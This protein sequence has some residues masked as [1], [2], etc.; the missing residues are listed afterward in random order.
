MARRG[1][2]WRSVETFANSSSAVVKMHRG[3]FAE[4]ADHV[5]AAVGSADRIGARFYVH[6]N[7][8]TLGISAG[9][10][11]TL[12]P[13][14]V[15]L[16]GDSLREQREVGH[17]RGQWDVLVGTLSALENH[18]RADLAGDIL[19]TIRDTPLATRYVTRVAIGMLPEVAK[20]ADRGDAPDL[21]VL[22]GQVLDALDEIVDASRDFGTSTVRIVT[23]GRF[24]LELDGKEVPSSVWGSKRARQLCKQLVAVR[25][26]PITR[27]QLID[28]LWPD[29]PAI[30][31]LGA[32]LSV[33]LSTVRRAL[34]G[35]ID[36][37]RQTVRLDL[38]EVSTDLEELYAANDDDAVVA[39][40]TGEFL[41]EDRYDDWTNGTS[42]PLTV[43]WTPPPP[44]PPTTAP[45]PIPSV[46]ELNAWLITSVG[47]ILVVGDAPD[48]PLGA[49]ATS[50][51]GAPM[52]GSA[53]TPSGGVWLAYSDGSVSAHGVEWHGDMAGVTLTEPIT[54]IAP[55]P[56][57]TGYWLLGTDGGVF[58]FGDAPFE[59]SPAGEGLVH[60]AVDL[61]ITSSGAGY[62]V[63]AS[64]GEVYAYGD[65]PYL[66]GPNTI[67]GGLHAPATSIT[68]GE[69]GYWVI[70][71]DG[72]V[73]AYDE[74]F[75]GSLPSV[76]P[77]VSLPDATRIRVAT[78]GSGYYITTHDGIVYEFGTVDEAPRRSRRAR[79]R[80]GRRR[81]DRL[82]L[83]A[84]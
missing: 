62:W 83:E 28:H 4:A 74:A 58:A 55:A 17:V 65:A 57:G 37:D 82:R 14:D 9:A 42:A 46:G 54:G 64:N 6:Y 30:D 41:P 24:A 61:A 21:T 36:A 48:P 70:A 1:I 72:G 35:G 8:N 43:V 75:R 18:G 79:C 63:V 76:L 60:P 49:S 78:S 20:A 80:R 12:A 47:R 59:G 5:R 81:H 16:M 45:P 32:R 71:I 31:R 39:A 51:S 66:G 53:P 7:M 27:D 44:P 26:W 69:D 11:G 68:A 29:D 15:A 73:F 13:S 34:G 22:V 52:V 2:E 3:E 77:S 40:Y 33:Q 10:A 56:A 67:P 19:R 38:D 23:L 50:A 25:G 84:R